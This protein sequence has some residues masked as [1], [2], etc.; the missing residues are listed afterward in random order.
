MMESSMRD[1][2]KDLSQK[3]K[4]GNHIAFSTVA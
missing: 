3:E 4:H 1:P 2:R